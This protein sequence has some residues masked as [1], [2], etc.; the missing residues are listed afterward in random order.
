MAIDEATRARWRREVE[1]EFASP[2]AVS[3]WRTWH[4][5]WVACT[6]PLTDR[7]LQAARLAPGL[8][9]LDVGSGTGEPALTIAGLVGPVGR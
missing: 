3:G 2:R 4:E 5:A 6:R 9:V 7:L 8:R 1:R